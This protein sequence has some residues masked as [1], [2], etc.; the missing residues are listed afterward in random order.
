MGG[1]IQ[2]GSLT[3]DTGYSETAHC[4]GMPSYLEPISGSMH[5]PIEEVYR[6]RDF[7][8]QNQVSKAT[9][10]YLERIRNSMQKPI[11]GLSSRSSSAL[12]K[13]GGS[14]FR[15]AVA[16]PAAR[17]RKKV[18]PATHGTQKHSPA[19]S[20]NRKSPIYDKH[21][22]EKFKTHTARNITHTLLVDSLGRKQLCSPRRRQ[23]R[24]RKDSS[25]YPC[26]RKSN[27]SIA[28]YG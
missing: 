24:P 26:W 25:D 28:A 17:K 11:E 7:R 13:G 23:L 5:V 1:E 18:N 6:I 3:H 4:I 22:L 2:R 10:A 16:V 20:G 8:N 9:R 12:N 15:A 21:R 19:T 27:T 14:T